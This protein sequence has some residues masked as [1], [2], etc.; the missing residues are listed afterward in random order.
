M[1]LE[2]SLVGMWWAQR[3]CCVLNTP[4]V[5]VGQGCSCLIDDL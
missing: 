2:L 1:G 5:C 3:F 4:H